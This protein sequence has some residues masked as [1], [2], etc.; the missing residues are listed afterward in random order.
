MSGSKYHLEMTEH[1]AVTLSL[2]ITMAV[3]FNNH[4]KMVGEQTDHLVYVMPK[5]MAGVLAQSTNA[6]AQAA[7][8]DVDELADG[9][10]VVALA[11]QDKLLA[12]LE[13]FFSA[14]VA[15]PPPSVDGTTSQDGAVQ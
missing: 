11:L 4:M 15:E 2:L 13:Q 8:K 6:L 10:G 14:A 5:D 12:Q 1:E 7:S 3:A 9:M